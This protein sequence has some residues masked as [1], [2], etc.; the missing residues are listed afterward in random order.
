MGQLCSIPLVCFTSLTEKHI[1]TIGPDMLS[2]MQPINQPTADFK[3][4]TFLDSNQITDTIIRQI[5]GT[6]V[7]IQL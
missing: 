7:F 2:I 1:V 5:T 3:I 6:F 4:K